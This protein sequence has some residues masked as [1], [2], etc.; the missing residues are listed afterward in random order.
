LFYEDYRNLISEPFNY[1]DFRLTND[2]E[3]QTQGVEFG[4]HH[5][6]ANG[7]EWGA[8]YVYLDADTETPF[9]A[10]LRPRQAGSLWG[11]APLGAH[12]ALSGVYYG[13]DQVADASYD[14]LDLTLSHRIPLPKGH[15]DLQLNY[16]HYPDGI[17]AYT[18]ISS[19]TPNV[20]LIDGQDRVFISAAFT[21]F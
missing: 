18:E 13:A 20:A 16:R 21:F 6:L 2:G 15:I 7:F 9:E 8:S 5:T 10:T 4:L 3:L 12:S 14:R 19:L 17:N 1:V 11:I